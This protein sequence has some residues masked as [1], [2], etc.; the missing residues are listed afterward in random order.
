MLVLAIACNVV[1]SITPQRALEDSPVI[2]AIRAIEDSP[3]ARMRSDLENSTAFRF[4][5]EMENSPAMKAIREIVLAAELGHKSITSQ[6]PYTSA[7]KLVSEFDIEQI[8]SIKILELQM[9]ND[10]IKLELQ[11]L[12]AK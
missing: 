5:Q 8:Q 1:F 12:K 3:V 7:I 11:N 9:E 4:M 2:R 10:R 6:A